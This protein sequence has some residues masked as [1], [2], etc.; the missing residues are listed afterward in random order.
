MQRTKKLKQSS[1]SVTQ[2]Q[3]ETVF[4]F[5]FYANF[6][7][8]GHF[9]HFGRPYWTEEINGKRWFAMCTLPLSFWT[10]WYKKYQNRL[11]GSGVR[12]EPK[13]DVTTTFIT[14]IW[15]TKLWPLNLKK[16]QR[17]VCILWVKKL[18]TW[19]RLTLFKSLYRPLKMVIFQRYASAKVDLKIKYEKKS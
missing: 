12:G 7:F 4:R 9:R 18:Q 11:I 19:A 8:N 17:I 16:I 14:I 15:S 1:S 10:F 13:I 2:N 6:H 5:S 3:Y